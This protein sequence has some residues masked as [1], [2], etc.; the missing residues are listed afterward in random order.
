ML[1]DAQ[2]Q[3]AE[4]VREAAAQAGGRA[5]EVMANTPVLNAWM[6]DR[7]APYVGG[8]VLEVGSG[9]GNM[10]EVIRGDADSLTVSE[11]D[12][13]HLSILESRFADDEAVTV[14]AFDLEGEPPP[15]IADQRFDA[16][17]AINVIE[18]IRND[19]LAVKRLAALLKPGGRLLVYVPACPFAFGSMDEALGHYR[20]YTEETLEALIDSSGLRRFGRASYMNLVGLP[21]WFLNGRILRRSIPSPAQM[22]LFERIMPLVRLE[23]RFRLPIGLGLHVAAERL[24]EDEK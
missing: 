5:L 20:R 2:D 11:I 22:T 21:G 17:I 4:R 16:I 23:D 18:H 1:P 9:I 24:A 3:L 14:S 6:Y 8:N 12:P 15:A 10:S 19:E 7:F 13:A